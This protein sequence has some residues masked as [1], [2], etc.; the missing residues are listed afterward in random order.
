[1]RGKPKVA[2]GPFGREGHIEGFK[3]GNVP[4][5]DFGPRFLV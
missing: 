5:T 2:C 4:L 3:E 1:M